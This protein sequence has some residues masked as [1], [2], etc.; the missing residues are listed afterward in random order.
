VDTEVFRRERGSRIMGNHRRRLRPGG[1]RLAADLPLLAGLR[2]TPREWMSL[3]TLMNPQRFT[4]Q[5]EEAYGRMWRHWC[6]HAPE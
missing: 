3:S 4:R 5:L 1:G 2:A 6:R